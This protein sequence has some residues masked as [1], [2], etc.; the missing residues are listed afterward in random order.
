MNNIERTRVRVTATAV[1]LLAI[2]LVGCSTAAIEE[3]I[4]GT[5]QCD[6]GPIVYTVVDT[7]DSTE[8]Q[9]ARGAAYQEALMNAVIPET[10]RM[11]GDLFATAADG[12][13]IANGRWI[14]DGAQFRQTAGGNKTVAAEG[15][16]RKAQKD[17]GRHVQQLLRAHSTNGSDVLGALQR[18]AV[19]AKDVPAGRRKVI[20]LL[21]DGVLVVKGHYSAYK[22]PLN[23][24]E[25]RKKFIARLRAG[26]ELPDLRGV[27]VFLGGVGV[28]VGNRETAKAIIAT[29][30]TLV[31][32]AGG[33]LES[34][35]S[36]LRFP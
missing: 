27:E 26:A 1:T 22:T 9:R 5:Q 25:R 21:T 29:W 36:T 24:R 6:P 31:G 11:C 3:N 28:G 13:A 34:I 17:L 14:I 7:S 18:V 10:A 2:L 16:A 4:V 33:E 35:D 12:N 19:T 8:Q 32:E 20:V 30:T 23:T 15:R